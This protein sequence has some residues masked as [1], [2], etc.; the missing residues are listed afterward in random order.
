MN[1]VFK[2]V[3]IE[4]EGKIHFV[5]SGDESECEISIIDKNTDL[6]VHKTNIWLTQGVT[7]WI[8]TG[9]KNAKRLKNVIFRVNYNGKNYDE[10]LNFFGENRFLVINSEQIKL[11]NC[12]D[13]LFPI[14]CEIFYD[15]VYERDFVKMGI[16]DIVVDI[17]ANYGV[18]SLYTQMFKPKKVYSVEP[19]R[20]TFK[21]MKKNLDKYGVVCINKS[22]SSEN[23]YESFAITDVNGNNYAL[24][25]IDGYHPSSMKNQEIVETITINQLISDYDIP[26][27][28]FLKVDCEG[29]EYDLFTTID[30]EYLKNKIQKTAIE[31]HSSNIKDTV[32]ST[33]LAN[34]FVIEDI[35]GG[36]EVGLIYAYN[37]NFN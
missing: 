23:G 33:L 26:H 13:D 36:S 5:F 8:S 21:Q 31:Y 18:F 17:G 4:P 10:G 14:V 29:G 22:I 28:N 16:D 6:V 15:K 7:Y 12:G 1:N 19:V 11:N 24:K 9:E 32:V 30:K 2:I 35:M 27:I 3:N 34:G 25:N 37:K 20:T